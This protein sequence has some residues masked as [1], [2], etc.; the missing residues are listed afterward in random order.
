MAE[1]RHD[2][3][4]DHRATL[5]RIFSHPASGNIEWRQ[6]RSLL[7]SVGG[8]TQEHNGK[9]RVTLDGESVVLTPPHGKD[10]D[11]QMIVDLRHLLAR[12]GFT[13]ADR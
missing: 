7:E 2:V 13:P 11:R 12:A 3:D 10:V 9:L 5:A 4:S 8:T 1:Q 6:V